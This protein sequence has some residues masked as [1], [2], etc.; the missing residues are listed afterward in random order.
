MSQYFSLL[1]NGLA[2]GDLEAIADDLLSHHLI[3]QEVYEGLELQSKTKFQKASEVITNVS[4]KVIM[5]PM[6]EF[7]K[8]LDILRKQKGTEHLVGI[9]EKSYGKV[10]CAR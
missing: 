4:I 10:V 7:P 2:A 6:E 1:V 8:F 9:M 5:N 3:D